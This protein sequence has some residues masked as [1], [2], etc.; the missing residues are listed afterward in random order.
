MGR[1][2]TRIGQ[3][4][5]SDELHASLSDAEAVPILI[6][7]LRAT[8][9]LPLSSEALLWQQRVQWLR[10][11]SSRAQADLS[12]GAVN[13]VAGAQAGVQ[14][15]RESGS[16]LAAIDNE[17]FAAA[18]T[19]DGLTQHADSPQRPAQPG[20]QSLSARRQKK[21]KTVKK[22][23][24][25]LLQGNVAARSDMAVY[26]D[27]VFDAFRKSVGAKGW[28]ELLRLPDMSDEALVASMEEWLEE[29]L[30]GLRSWREVQALPWEDLIRYLS[31]C[32]VI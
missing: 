15:Q 23:S 6:A 7:Q 8:R 16:P 17:I 14:G 9:K 3:L 5:L 26:S 24:R 25:Q 18:S 12:G 28:E 21:G 2:R 1:M 20:T 11:L 13:S 22:N 31:D 30:K 32:L 19:E 4:V 27:S 10:L 29:S